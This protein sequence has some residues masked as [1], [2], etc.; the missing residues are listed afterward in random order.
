[1]TGSSPHPPPEASNPTKD[2]VATTGTRHDIDLTLHHDDLI[3]ILSVS[4]RPG[5][6]DEPRSDTHESKLT[7]REEY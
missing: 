2:R 5:Y 7:F 3:S 1:M 6:E 4:A